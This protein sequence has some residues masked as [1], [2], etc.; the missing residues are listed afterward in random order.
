MNGKGTSTTSPGLQVVIEAVFPF[1]E[2]GADTRIPGRVGTG[3]LADDD[4]AFPFLE[5]NRVALFQS[6]GN[7]NRAGYGYLSFT[8]YCCYAW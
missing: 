2:C 1:S 7:T 3:A 5:E 4:V 6:E 8:G